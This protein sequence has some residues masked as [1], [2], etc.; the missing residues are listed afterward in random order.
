MGKASPLSTIKEKCPLTSYRQT[1]GSSSRLWHVFDSNKTESV[2]LPK[3]FETKAD[4]ILLEHG[5]D[6]NTDTTRRNTENFLTLKKFF[7]SHPLLKYFNLRV[8]QFCGN[9]FFSF[10]VNTNEIYMSPNAY[11]TG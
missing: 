9:Y 10:Q 1:T 3:Y 2:P 5:F 11:L 7:S 6:S 8:F 4:L